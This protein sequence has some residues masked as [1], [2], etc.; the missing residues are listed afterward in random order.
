MR[1]RTD[2]SELP[3]ADGWSSAPVVRRRSR[4][5]RHLPA[6][7]LMIPLVVGLIGAPAGTRVATGDE[8]SDAKDRQEQLKKEVANQKEQ[9]AKLQALQSGLAAEIRQTKV[10]LNAINADLAEVKAKIKKME[11][12][13]KAVQAAYDALV[14][15]LRFMNQEL[16]RIQAQEAAKRQELTERRA[17]LADRVRNAYDTDRTSPLE[18]FLSG[19]TFT[20]MLTEMS[21]YIDVGEQDK[22]LAQQIGKDQ[23]ALAAIHQT[24]AETKAQTD[25]LRLETADQKRTLDAALVDLTKAKAQLK[26]LE[27]A[28]ARELQ[29]QRHMFA[30]LA[31]N[32]GNAKKALAAA[33]A[34]Q[35]KMAA[36]ISDL[37]KAQEQHGNIPSKFNGTLGWPMSG[38]V[39]QNYGCTGF[40][41][42]PPKGSCPHFHSGIDIAA[43][44]YTKVKAA[45]SGTVVFAGPNPYD[46]YPKAWIV[47]IAHSTELVTWYAHLDNGSH[48]IPVHAGQHVSKGQTIGYNGMT[49]RTTGPHLHWMVEYRGN[50]VNPRLFL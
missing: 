26:K 18:A 47:I 37:I 13:I 20:D 27:A 11:A 43:P 28:T 12:K 15:Q 46:A 44:K 5:R 39:T 17:L 30:V 42:E 36:R 48:P 19:G 34:A 4:I 50:F 2:R 3:I 7:F 6:L 16:G 38:T 9:I 31:R 35:R 10:Q 24:V 33:A 8:L 49:G 1:R 14:Y 25:A 29:R 21:Y 22:A 41:A 32:K 40:P 45:G 23:E